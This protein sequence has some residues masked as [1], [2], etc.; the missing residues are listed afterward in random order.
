MN[1]IDLHVHTTASDGSLKPREVVS[2]AREKG[3]RAVAITD[4]D[5]IDG[6]AEAIEAGRELGVEV[7]PGVE[8]SVDWPKGTLHMLGYFPHAFPNRLDRDLQFLKDER[9]SRNEKMLK[10]LNELGVKLSEKDV[11]EVSG[12]GLVGRPHFARALIK[13]GYVRSNEEAFERYL[14]KGAPAYVEKDRLSPDR[15][16][17]MILDSE[18]IPVL[19][20]PITLR[21]YHDRTLPGLLSRL[22]EY[23]LM[24]IEV[25]YYLDIETDFDYLIG[26]AERFNLLVTGGTD[27]HGENL[28]TIEIG[29]GR[30]NLRIPY[31]LLEKLKDARPHR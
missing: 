14:K 6:C 9:A 17:R 2:R 18:G 12:G 13:L 24:G 28:D 8:I 5:T 15:A 31:S 22:K 1:L 7:I 25:Y 16:V 10:R 23:G 20:H 19:A 11:R 29:V 4:H 21:E 30:G 3:L 27:Y 26:L